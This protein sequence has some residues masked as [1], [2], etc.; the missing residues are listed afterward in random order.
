MLQRLLP[1]LGFLFS[2]AGLASA[3]VVA[4]DDFSYTGAL[5]A[6]G[7][8][9]HSG[10]G[11]KVV[12]AAGGF[13]TLNQGAGS[14]EDVSLTFPAFGA[15]DTIYASFLLRIPSGNPVNPSTNGLYF[16][17]FKNNGTFFHGRV[18]VLAPSAGGD[19]RLAISDTSSLSAGASW[20][21]DSAFDTD[22][23]IVVSWNAATAECRLWVDPLDS[24]S[25]SVSTFG[26]FPGDLMEGF[27]LR[28]S[29][30][31]TGFQQ[32]DD[33]VV[34][35]SFADVCP[36]LDT[37]PPSLSCP[38]SVFARDRKAAP[39]ELVTFT[40]TAIDDTDPAPTVVCVPPSGSLFLP[41]TTLVT[42]TATDAAGN[43]ST[44]TFPVTVEPTA[45][46]R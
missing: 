37:T 45:R 24:S 32:V 12:Q 2:A 29:S 13:A 44:C 17:H 9:A 15:T 41:G 5:T 31:Y 40:V 43:Q 3:Q 36:T 30:D 26:T 10:A 18:G 23:K 11:N 39:G 28:Q 46:R 25:P 38:S 35:R 19:F 1:A 6:N 4:S 42:C 21:S 14:G 7:W 20:T 34:G 8:V 16:A 33:V 27:A 22:Y